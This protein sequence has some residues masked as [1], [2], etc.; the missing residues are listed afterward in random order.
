[1]T[2]ISNKGFWLWGVFDKKDTENLKSANKILNSILIGPSFH[3]HLTLFGPIKSLNDSDIKNIKKLC[4]DTK[5]FELEIN[6][7]EIGASKYQSIYLVPKYEKILLDMRMN[8]IKKVKPIK[9]QLEYMPHISLYYG[10]KTE[11]DKKKAISECDL[12]FKTITFKSICYVYVDE[13]KNL[14][15]IIKHFDL[16]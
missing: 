7:L 13:E 8:L 9:K 2:I 12:T 5:K 1:M 16:N 15:E 6:K 10:N 14:W 3:P 4:T 11:I